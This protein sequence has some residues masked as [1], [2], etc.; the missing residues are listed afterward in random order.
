[1]VG[2][3][4]G[5]YDS[6][7]MADRQPSKVAGMVLVD[8]SF[9]DQVARY[10]RVTPSSPASGSIQSPVLVFLGKCA[11]ALRAGTVRPGGPDPDGCLHGPPPPSEYPPELSAALD[12]A[13][14]GAS[15]ETIAT[16]MDNIAF[17]ASPKLMEQDAKIAIKPNRNYGSMPL[18]VL[19]AAEDGSSP[20]LPAS[21]NRDLAIQLAEKQRAHTELAALS[22][23]GVHRIVQGSSHDIPHIKPQAV[24]DAIDQLVDQVRRTGRGATLDRR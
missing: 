7:L 17:Y 11:A 24:I 10:E 13:A 3:S 2:H 15:A 23:R 18:L 12:Q 6:L 5:A 14:A 20:A 1:M 21:L 8:P 16:A 19:S 22:T 4:L 9:P